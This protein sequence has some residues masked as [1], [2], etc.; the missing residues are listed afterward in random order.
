MRYIVG[1]QAAMKKC[2]RALLKAIK[3]ALF[4]LLIPLALFCVVLYL[5]IVVVESELIV[6]VK[7]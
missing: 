6:R 2:K 4:F 5:S 3:A 1:I 7:R